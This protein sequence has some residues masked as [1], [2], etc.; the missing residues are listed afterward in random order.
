MSRC[1]NKDVCHS[2][3]IN[4]TIQNVIDYENNNKYRQNKKNSVENWEKKLSKPFKPKSFLGKFSCDP[5]NI[6]SK[7]MG[8]I[9]IRIM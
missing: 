8:T 9:N 4:K 5:L 2:N 3:I 1:D 6:F 7:P